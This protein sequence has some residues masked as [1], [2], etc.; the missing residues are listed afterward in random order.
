MLALLI[1]FLPRDLPASTGFLSLGTSKTGS[2]LRHP[3][4]H[5][6]IPGPGCTLYLGLSWVPCYCCV[7]LPINLWHVTS[8]RRHI[9]CICARC[10]SYGFHMVIPGPCLQP[11]HGLWISSVLGWSSIFY[12][13]V[14]GQCVLHVSLLITM[15][16]GLHLFFC[17]WT[18]RLIP[19]R[20]EYA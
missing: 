5:L 3:W 12:R 16:Q 13:V 14:P 19:I 11:A 7:F 8:S 20:N 2:C 1:Q 10:M 6:D 18:I 15:P 4:P 17:W 9:K